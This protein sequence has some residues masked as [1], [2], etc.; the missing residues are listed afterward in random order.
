MLGD[1]TIINK[2][3]AQTVKTYDEALKGIQKK[4]PVKGNVI[5]ILQNFII[6]ED[7]VNLEALTK[8]DPITD[9]TKKIINALS[10]TSVPQPLATLHLD[11]INKLE[12]LVE[13]IEDIKLYD[14]DVIVA[15]AGIS[16]YE[17]NTELLESA[18]NNLGNA[19]EQK[20]SN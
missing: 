7:T 19:I 1:L 13:N 10:K 9:Q 15:L 6:D 20:L 16:K 17:K 3:D 4:Y 12:V 2:S 11:F 8:L 14:K 5:S 18:S